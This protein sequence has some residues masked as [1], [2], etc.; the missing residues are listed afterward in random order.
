MN[1][2]VVEAVTP[3]GGRSGG[4]DTVVGMRG[5]VI[6][7]WALASAHTVFR[8]GES[9]F[10]MLAAAM[11]HRPTEVVVREPHCRAWAA[12]RANGS[13]PAFCAASSL[14]EL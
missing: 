6:D 11:H 13:V 2:G 9:T 4:R 5:A 10:G 12:M 7:L 1:L 3:G 14:W 8:T